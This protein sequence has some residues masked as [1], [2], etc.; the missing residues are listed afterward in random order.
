MVRY[1]P[2]IFENLILLSIPKHLSIVNFDIRNSILMNKDIGIMIFPNSD[3][4][5]AILLENPI[6]KIE[7]VRTS[8]HR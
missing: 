5:T 8:V 3:N 4:Q 2:I 1:L 7:H 6:C